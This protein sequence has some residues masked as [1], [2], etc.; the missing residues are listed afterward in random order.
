MATQFTGNDKANLLSTALTADSGDNIAITSTS[1]ATALGLGEKDTIVLGKDVTSFTASGG[2][3]NDTILV[4]GTATGSNIQGNRGDD[5]IRVTGELKTTSVKGGENADT[6]HISSGLTSAS[7]FGGEGNDSITFDKSTADITSTLFQDGQDNNKFAITSQSFS[8]SSLIAGSGVD[9]ITLTVGNGIKNSTIKAE[10]ANDKITISSDITG[11]VVAGGD[12]NDET[13]LSGAIQ[14]STIYGGSGND[15]ITASIGANEIDNSVIQDGGGNNVFK[16]TSTSTIEDFTVQ[17]GTGSDSLSV[18]ANSED[19]TFKGGADSD[20][21]L[22]TGTLTDSTLYGGSGS[23]TFAVTGAVTSSLLQSGSGKNIYDLGA[24]TSATI[25]GGTGVD[26]VSVAGTLKGAYTLNDGNDVLAVTGAGSNDVDATIKMGAGNDS[27]FA[28]AELTGSVYLGTGKDTIQIDDKATTALIQTS[29][30][31]NNVFKLDDAD[32]ITL[33][34][35]DGND[36][37]IAAAG[38]T[39]ADGTFGAGDDTVNLDGALDNS[40]IKLEKG[41][42]DFDLDVASTT[43]TIYGGE[44]ADT[45]NFAKK[46]TKFVVSDTQ[47]VAKITFTEGLE[48]TTVTTGD[49]ADTVANTGTNTTKL[50]SIALGGGNDTLTTGAVAFEGSSIT[51]GDGADSIKLGAGVAKSGTTTSS[52]FLGAGNDSLSIATTVEGAEI[53]SSAGD[54]LI[55]IS[56]GGA[57]TTGGTSAV[58]ITLGSGADTVAFGTTAAAQIGGE[59]TIK[60]GGGSDLLIAGDN[61]STG[62]TLYGGDGTDTVSFREAQTGDDAFFTNVTSIEHVE[63]VESSNK[64]L[65]LAAKAQAAGIVSATVNGTTG[66]IDASTYTTAVGLTLTAGSTTSDLTGGLGADTLIGGAGNSALVTKDGND[67]ITGDEGVDTF[68]IDGAAAQTVTIN[69]F[70]TGGNETLT[71]TNA[72]ATVN[73]TIKAAT[74]VV[75]QNADQKA[76]VNVTMTDDINAGATV[77]FDAIGGGA[78]EKGFNVSS[79]DNNNGIKIIGSIETD[80]ITAGAGKD[81]LDGGKGADSIT[82]GGGIDDFLYTTA[83][84]VILSASTFAGA[85]Y[86]A[87]DTMTFA[88]GVD[89]IT[90]FTAGTGG[91][92]FVGSNAG[93]PTTAIGQATANGLA[94]G[95]TY[96]LS[97]AWTTSTNV[98]TIAADGAGADTMILEGD[99]ANVTANDD[100]NILIGVDSDDF[101]AANFT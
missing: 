41:D 49:S 6:I 4:S 51:A 26:S 69:D 32:T 31:D 40:I 93:V 35:G 52:I 19:L 56:N 95:T 87:G 37:L 66:N 72:L 94:G 76:V 7:V 88:N 39:Y 86:A 36:S 3:E 81:T 53:T 99:G 82:G 60:L 5:T 85:V 97:G 24:A 15:S 21:I 71:A 33:I 57:N 42:D 91:S 59:T 23:D 61:G 1:D 11:S 80:T 45:I 98:F 77:S 70:G 73:M 17:G 55:D 12:G 9:D 28:S 43:S 20:S 78:G 92:K 46:T 38:I 63:Y 30:S 74:G 100:I 101:V 18:T 89:V 75:A 34:A 54:N 96:F 62:F 8:A 84:S 58:G 47:G 2:T 65:T 22:V 83:D 29:G 48:D 25:V 79:A 67:V 44:G 16:V 27:V 68:T 90:G 64:T 10:A 13:T 50:S 14:S